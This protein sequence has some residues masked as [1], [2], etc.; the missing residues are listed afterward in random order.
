MAEGRIFSENDAEQ[1]L[2]ERYKTRAICN[3]CGR[4]SCA[5]GEVGGLCDMPQPDGNR[6]TGIMKASDEDEKMDEPVTN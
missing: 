4:T 3:V 2:N 5:E 6:C 1:F